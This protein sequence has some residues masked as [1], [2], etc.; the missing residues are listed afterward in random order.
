MIRLATEVQ[1]A[2]ADRTDACRAARRTSDRST[3]AALAGTRQTRA[4]AGCFRSRG[5]AT[6][7]IVCDTFAI[8]RSDFCFGGLN[9]G[10]IVR[11]V[12]GRRIITGVLETYE[13]GVHLGPRDGSARG[14][15]EAKRRASEST[16]CEG[17]ADER[18]NDVNLLD[19]SR[20][21]LDGRK[22]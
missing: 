5:V 8:L 14:L 1:R 13:I 2:K 20:L 12:A 11:V 4:H 22:P 6:R 19:L 15:C 21:K 3:G 10:R 17:K 18:F 7:C 9:V 16:D